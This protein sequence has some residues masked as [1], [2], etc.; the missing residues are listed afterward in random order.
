MLYT[1]L[2]LP[3]CV[4]ARSP[5]L[6]AAIVTQ[7]RAY[8]SVQPVHALYLARFR[9]VVGKLKITAGGAVPLSYGQIV[10]INGL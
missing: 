7:R 3:R 2:Q 9:V 5:G 4:E 10:F 6:I 8:S 1:L